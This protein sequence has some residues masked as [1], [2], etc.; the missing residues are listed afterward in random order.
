MSGIKLADIR[1]ENK[2]MKTSVK[3]CI[4]ALY[5]N[6]GK[7]TKA[8]LNKYGTK[9]QVFALAN[10]I[11]MD[12]HIGKQA[13]KKDGT[14]R[15]SKSGNVIIVKVSLDL[16]TRWFVSHQEQAATIAENIKAEIE[17]ERQKKERT[18]KVAKAA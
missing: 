4:K 1:K 3:G 8:L 15:F 6:E 10:R 12:M 2:E 7:Q 14:L 13:E 16:V 11:S 18:I 5:A 9:E 17:T